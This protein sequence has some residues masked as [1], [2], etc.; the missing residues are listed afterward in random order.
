MNPKRKRGSWLERL[1][2]KIGGH[3]VRVESVKWQ[4]ELFPDPKRT[5]RIVDRTEESNGTVTIITGAKK[6]SEE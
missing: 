1:P 2:T 6:P 5:Y 3:V 4:Y